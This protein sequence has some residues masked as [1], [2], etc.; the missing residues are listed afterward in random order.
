MNNLSFDV[1]T[2][3]L[4]FMDIK[5]ERKVE[6]HYPE[7]RLIEEKEYLIKKIIY[8]SPKISLISTIWKKYILQY[9]RNA[10]G[11][12]DDVCYNNNGNIQYSNKILNLGDIK[13]NVIEGKE[14]ERLKFIYYK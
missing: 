5:F 14:K 3:I 10:L 4:S 6:Y 11:N 2:N 8:L 7:N 13:D 12:I 9:F 1:I